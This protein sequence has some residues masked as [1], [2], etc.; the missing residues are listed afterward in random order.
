MASHKASTCATVHV[1][2][3]VA[4]HLR[5]PN[6]AG[7]PR[8]LT[9]LAAMTALSRAIT[10]SQVIGRVVA[11]DEAGGGERSSGVD[12]GTGSSALRLGIRAAIWRT[13]DGL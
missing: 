5:P 10:A 3:G 8:R 2:N 13:P 6:K 1:S 12:G 4:Y 9:L 11:I 7:C